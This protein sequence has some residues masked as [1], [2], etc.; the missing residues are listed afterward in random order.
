M[1]RIKNNWKYFSNTEIIILVKSLIKALTTCKFKNI[2]HR[3]I[4]PQNILFLNNNWYIADFGVAKRLGYV[5][6]KN[7][8][9]KSL[10]DFSISGT[11]EYTSSFSFFNKYKNL[12]LS[13]FLDI[14][15]LFST[16]NISQSN[17]A[18]NKIIILKIF[19]IIPTT[20]FQITVKILIMIIN[21]QIQFA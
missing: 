3:D 18:D 14:W 16:K 9:K 1:Y 8:D 2:Q 20:K 4:K 21:N 10:I 13:F 15:T 7:F 11:P 19:K 17:K 6:S 5:N 12:F